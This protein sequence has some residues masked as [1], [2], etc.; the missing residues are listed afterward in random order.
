VKLK[1]TQKEKPIAKKQKN[2]LLEETEFGSAGEQ[3]KEG[4]SSPRRKKVVKGVAGK[5]VT[6]FF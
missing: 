5:S 3:P 4:Y 1:V 6:P 2:N